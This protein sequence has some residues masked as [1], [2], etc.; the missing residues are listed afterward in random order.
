[1]ML[2]SVPVM[3]LNMVLSP[4]QGA[5]RRNIWFLH[6]V[7][8]PVFLFLIGI[9]VRV[10]GLEK[11]NNRPCVI[12]SNHRSAIDF[13]INAHAYPGIFR[14][15][16]KQELL[17]V[18]VFGWVVRKMCLIVDRSS[19]Q[20]R[21]QS[22]IGLKEALNQ[23]WSIFIY[24]EGARNRTEKPLAP[25]YDGAFRVAIQTEA[26]LVVQTVKNVRNVSRT[27][28][29]ADLMPGTVDIIWDEPI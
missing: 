26:P 17:K 10:Q 23:G 7:F 19:P 1:M 9:R 27:V 18:P 6:Q 12:V 16:A 14:F 22:I 25:F 20:S 2:L 11:I 3:L 24:P 5:L 29:A 28:K 4:G 21:A 13:I 8:T 15:L